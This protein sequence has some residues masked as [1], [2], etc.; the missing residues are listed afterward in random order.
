MPTTTVTEDFNTGP[1]GA[2]ITTA[3]TQ[4][5]L[6]D[7]PPVFAATPARSGLSMSAP[8][9]ADETFGSTVFYPAGLTAPYVITYAE[10]WHYVTNEGGDFSDT[11]IGVSPFVTANLTDG[12]GIVGIGALYD[13]D[14]L[15][16]TFETILITFQY[17]DADG[18]YSST[19]TGIL[20]PLDEWVRVSIERTGNT[21]RTRLRTESDV[22]VFDETVETN[23]PAN[24]VGVNVDW[25]LVLRTWADDLTYTYMY[26][27][28]GRPVRMFP[29]HEAPR[30]TPRHDGRN[31]SSAPR[32]V[33]G[34]Q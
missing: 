26:G 12:S 8:G 32:V 16:P 15:S 3:N 31:M 5:A 17:M 13:I 29:I 14:P 11:V 20:W 24:A 6:V 22:T 18:D 30:M 23:G 19:S 34:F 1:D 2:D 4:A 25:S 33:G 7:G 9:G 27:G 21:V 10:C 28:R